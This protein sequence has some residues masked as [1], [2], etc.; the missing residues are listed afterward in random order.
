MS[1]VSSRE[2]STPEGNSPEGAGNPE[3]AGIQPPAGYTPP[4]PMQE[5][6]DGNTQGVPPQDDATAVFPSTPYGANDDQTREYSAVSG[7]VAPAAQQNQSYGQQGY[8]QQGQYQQG[9]G[10]QS[11]Y[12]QGY[13]QQGYNQQGGYGGPGQGGPGYG[14]PGYGGPGQGGPGYYGQPGDEQGGDKKKK[15]GLAWLWWLIGV[16]LVLVAAG[17]VYMFVWGPWSNQE[18]GGNNDPSPSVTQPGENS[19]TPG[20]NSENPGGDN[21]GGDDFFTTDPFG[22][23]GNNG[24]GDT[25][26]FGSNSGGGDT[27]PFGSNSGG[28]DSDPFGNGGG[29]SEDPFASA[30]D[31]LEEL[32]NLPEITMPPVEDLGVSR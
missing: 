17:L 8:G 12:Q 19:G 21:P 30:S 10:Q 22:N 9:Y 14:G 27:D 3:S 13:G 2:N 20:W 16:L 26:P 4:P 18:N 23:S 15:G 11:Q 25:D 28:G 5:S 31:I 7:P 1:Y 29:P 32:E 6:Q 24:G